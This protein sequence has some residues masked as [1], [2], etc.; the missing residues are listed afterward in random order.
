M[1]KKIWLVIQESN[2]DGDIL[3][4]VQPC[5]SER[6][7]KKVLAEWKNTILA[8]SKHFGKPYNSKSDMEDYEI[9]ESETMFHIND[10]NDAYYEEIDISESTLKP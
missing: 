6:T 2:V 9:E 8:E 3:I 1:E 10:P 7:A 4:N 5:E